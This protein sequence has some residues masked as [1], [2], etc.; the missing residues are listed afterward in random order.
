MIYRF[1]V[2][3]RSLYVQ[4]Q[5]G[6]PRADFARRAC[7]RERARRGEGRGETVGPRLMHNARPSCPGPAPAARR[8]SPAARRTPRQIT[9]RYVPPP[10]RRAVQCST[11]VTALS[12]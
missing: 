5:Y 8:T 2:T 3:Q 1:V 11:Y 9:R 12:L 6:R 10:P 7:A 4:V